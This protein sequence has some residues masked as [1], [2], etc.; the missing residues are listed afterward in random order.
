MDL[1]TDEVFRDDEDDP[2]NEFFQNPIYNALRVAQGLLRK[3][4]AKTADKRILLFT[5]EDDPFGSI[6]GAA[7]T[8]M[9][10]TTLQR[11]KKLLVHFFFY[12]MPK[13]L[14][15]QL[16][17][18]PYIRPGEEFNVSFF[19]SDL[20]GLEGDDLALFMPS[21]VEKY[22]SL[23]GFFFLF[24]QLNSLV[25]GLPAVDLSNVILKLKNLGH[26]VAAHPLNYHMNIRSFETPGT[27]N[28]A[29]LLLLLVHKAIFF[30]KSSSKPTFALYKEMGF[31][32]FQISLTSGLGLEDTKDQLRK[33]M[34]TKRIVKRISFIIA[35]GL[36]RELNSYALICPT[37]PGAT[38]WLDS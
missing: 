2:E 24:F 37:V 31:F 28:Y 38:T 4:S 35:N 5:N 10:R 36:S 20:I 3:G 14:V 33:R 30:F 29:T 18:Y 26:K 6:K 19:N 16:S 32:C 11:A 23:I 7:E 8:D 9:T 17:F 25:L 22:A 12:R 34:F 13:I 15:S 21:L 27:I 1:D